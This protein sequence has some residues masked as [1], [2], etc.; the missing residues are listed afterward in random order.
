MDEHWHQVRLFQWAAYNEDL[1]PELALLHAMPLGGQRPISVAKK[2]KAEGAKKGMP[3]IF[4]PVPM[5]YGEFTTIPGLYIELKT[6]KGRVSKYQQW[7]IEQ[8]RLQGFKVEVCRGWEAA[9]DMIC[10]YLQLEPDHPARR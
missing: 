1:V 4:L 5:H 3:D 8:L 7:W 10:D 6:E 9:R 2:M